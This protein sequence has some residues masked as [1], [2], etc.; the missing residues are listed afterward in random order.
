MPSFVT[1]VSGWAYALLGSS[2]P[3]GT[4]VVNATGSFIIGLLWLLFESE[5][6]Y[7]TPEVR[8]LVLTGF[9]GAFTTFSTYELETAN[10]IRSGQAELGFFNILS[11]SFLGLLCVALGFIA[12]RVVVAWLR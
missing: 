8:A 5:V 11:S 1:L 6:V 7:V 3:W 2:F 12:G 4:L 9:L 10:L